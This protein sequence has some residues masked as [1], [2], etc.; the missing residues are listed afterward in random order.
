VDHSDKSSARYE[1]GFG[2]VIAKQDQIRWIGIFN[3]NKQIEG[4]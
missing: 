3:I 1:A 2:S 4:I